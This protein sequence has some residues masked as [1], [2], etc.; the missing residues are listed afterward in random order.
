MK[1]VTVRLIDGMGVI[2]QD[3]YIWEDII[4]NQ[5]NDNNDFIRINNNIFAKNAINNILIEDIEEEVE[6]DVTTCEQA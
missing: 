6:K 4:F 2:I 5:L 3:K 1:K